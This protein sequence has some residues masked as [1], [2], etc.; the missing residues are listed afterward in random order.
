MRTIASVCTAVLLFVACSSLEK[1]VETCEPSDPV[2]ADVVPTTELC[3]A[4]FTRWFYDKATNSC[5]QVGYSGCSAK[6]FATKAECET[7]KCR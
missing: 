5:K 6:G 2:C 1:E 4:H 7:C 3:A